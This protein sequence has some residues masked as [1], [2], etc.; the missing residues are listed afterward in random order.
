MNDPRFSTDPPTRRSAIPP[1]SEEDIPF[2][3]CAQSLA[4]REGQGQDFPWFATAAA[5]TTTSAI[6]S[7]WGDAA[8]YRYA[9]EQQDWSPPEAIYRTIVRYGL[10]F[11][12]RA[13]ETAFVGAH[14][15]P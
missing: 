5:R 8:S 10:D 6:L 15:P 14:S 13:L 3:G 4:E 11:A 1:A 2:R 12:R 7:S 9:Y